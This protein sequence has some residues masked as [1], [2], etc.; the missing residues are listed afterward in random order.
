MDSNKIKGSVKK[1]SISWDSTSYFSMESPFVV[2][3]MPTILM[4]KELKVEDKLISDGVTLS[5]T[6]KPLWN[7]CSVLFNIK[8]FL[9]TITQLITIFESTLYYAHLGWLNDICKYRF[10]FHISTKKKNTYPKKSKNNII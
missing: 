5:L 9:V 7:T 10:M 2:L 1:N 8:R 4:S 3:Y 6:L